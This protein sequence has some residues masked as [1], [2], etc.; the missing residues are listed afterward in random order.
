MFAGARAA[1]S[2]RLRQ[3]GGSQWL[4]VQAAPDGGSASR[5]EAKTVRRRA[6]AQIAGDLPSTQTALPG[7]PENRYHLPKIGVHPS[8]PKSG[9]IIRGISAG[10]REVTLG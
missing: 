7:S 3:R 4:C 5:S 2:R 1:E 9:F 8:T 10:S 6:G